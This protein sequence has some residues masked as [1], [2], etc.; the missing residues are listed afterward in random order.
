MVALAH[1]RKHLDQVDASTV[2]LVVIEELYTDSDFVKAMVLGTDAI[3]ISNSALQ[4]IG[5]LGM[6]AC[7]T[8]NCPVGIATQKPHL[9]ERLIVPA[10]ATRLQNWFE[11]SVHLMSVLARACGHQHL[12]QFSKNDLSTINY[13]ISRLIGMRYAGI[14]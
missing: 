7:N 10:S 12:N 4:A 14:G 5:C 2:S 3:A 1:A 11:A 6:R 9:R 13:E 8:N